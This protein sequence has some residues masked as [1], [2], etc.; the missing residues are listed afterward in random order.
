MIEF[1]FHL[2]QILI[3]LIKLNKQAF[4]INILYMH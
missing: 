1:S 4:I 3:T 2:I